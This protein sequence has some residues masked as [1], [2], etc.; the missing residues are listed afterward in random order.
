MTPDLMHIPAHFC[1]GA[2]SAAAAAAT[3]QSSIPT[4]QLHF[5]QPAILASN[6]SVPASNMS[7]SQSDQTLV[8]P[9]PIV[10]ATAVAFY[11]PIAAVGTCAAAYMPTA[12]VQPSTTA[13]GQV[14]LDISEEST[15]VALYTEI[16]PHM[17][18]ANIFWPVIDSGY[19]IMVTLPLS[20]SS[21][22]S[23]FKYKQHPELLP[24]MTSNIHAGILPQLPASLHRRAAGQDNMNQAPERSCNTALGKQIMHTSPP[25][26]VSLAHLR[27]KSKQTTC[28]LTP[29]RLFAFAFFGSPSQLVNKCIC[30]DVCVSVTLQ[31]IPLHL[32]L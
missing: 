20:D 24:P 14:T 11:T 2:T 22:E 16:P 15:A 32:H 23:I 8:K 31:Q 17:A 4:I 7:L 6:T 26:A 9:S 21:V 18:W 1:M 10:P 27:T 19:P 13:A 5:T 12:V 30:H 29:P 3:G 28:S 25:W